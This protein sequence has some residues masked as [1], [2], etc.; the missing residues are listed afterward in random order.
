[1][2]LLANKLKKY[3]P[4]LLIII[5]AHVIQSA[6]LLTL[7]SYTSRMVDTGIQ[8][9]GF[10]YVSPLEIREDRFELLSQFM[11][12]AE[13]E[14]FSE[15]YNLIGGNFLLKDEFVESKEKRIEL[16]EKLSL[17]MASYSEFSKLDKDKQDE[18]I[19]VLKSNP[20]I[21]NARL[22]AM[23]VLKN[24][25][26]EFIETLGIQASIKEFEEAGNETFDIQ[27]SFLFTT[28]GKMI[29]ISLLAFIGAGIAHFTSAQLGTLLGRN[30][31][32]EVFEKV[33][34]FSNQEQSKFSTASLITRTTNDIQQITFVLT[35]FLRVA[36]LTPII[37]IGGVVLIL[38]SQPKMAWITGLGVLSLFILVGVL[39]MIVLPAMK[40]VPKQ[41]DDVNLIARENLT[42]VQV[43]RA[44]G[45]QPH[46]ESRFDKANMTL[47]KNYIFQDRT[48][49]ILAPLMIFVADIIG[50]SI[51][52]IAGHNMA[53][54]EMQVGQ[55]MSFTAY[56]MRIFFS[57]LN[58]SMLATMLPRSLV[59]LKRVEEVINTQNSIS[60]KKDPVVLENPK[61]IVEF[62]DVSF[63]FYDADEAMLKDINFVAKPG[64]TTAIIG[65]T[66]SGKSTVL[67]LILRFIDVSQGKIT[68]DGVDIRDLRQE[69]LRR[70]IGYV[71]QKGILFSG[72]IESNIAYGLDSISEEDMKK[73][74]EIAHADEFIASK[75]NGYD[76]KIAQEGSNVSDGQKQ[77]LSIARALAKKP[78]IL[79]F[80][81]SFSALDYKTDKSLRNALKEKITDTTVIIVAQRISTII[82][83]DNIIVLDEGEIEAM[84]TH[85]ELMKYSKIYQEIA[86]SQLS[87]KE[88]M[89]GGV[90]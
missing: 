76:S 9:S 22:D 58:I 50:C 23:P 87:E 26:K 72:T 48:M 52:W 83:A 25:P 13:K 6:A 19:K 15:S 81:D 60:D 57:F 28:G 4:Y 34:N 14:T 10:E 65:S 62:D 89:E 5:F 90:S 35:I 67:N 47:T 20:D 61:G 30:L 16:D 49:A 68:I 21:E 38:K 82:D 71:P 3:W 77:R 75:D 37:S 41:L 42:G 11:T 40:R 51:I 1:M 32:D 63:K 56:T 64:E 46:E 24:Y 39:F 12:E 85:K 69:D 59:S 31:R 79:L 88:L 43:I 44:F 53:A 86:R 36:L 54:G 17:P 70:M 27:K 7:P 29:L 80:D 74:A 73:A 33:I 2:K 45:R 55:M 18:V 84:G 8:N 78:K 66:G